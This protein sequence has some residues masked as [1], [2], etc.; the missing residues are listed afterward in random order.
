[1]PLFC[2][3]NFLANSRFASR[4][5]A[6]P[7]FL[8]GGNPQIGKAEGDAPVQAY[9]ARDVQPLACG[10][11]TTSLRPAACIIF[12][13]AFHKPRIEPVGS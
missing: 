4:K 2:G 5:G 10:Q 11:T 13:S 8:S 3:A 9:I 7:R 6:K 12:G 1:M